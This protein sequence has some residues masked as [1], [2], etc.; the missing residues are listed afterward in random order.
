MKTQNI[1]LIIFYGITA[2]TYKLYVTND[3]A[4]LGCDTSGK[5]G[6]QTGYTASP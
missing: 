6:R 5:R 3:R 2:R 1:V 4:A